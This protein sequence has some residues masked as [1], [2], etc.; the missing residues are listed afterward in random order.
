LDYLHALDVGQDTDFERL[1]GAFPGAE[2]NCILFPGWIESH[3]MDDVGRELLRLMELGKRF[4][5]FSFT[6]LEVDSRL[7]GDVLFEFHET[8]RRCAMG[9]AKQ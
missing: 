9:A 8:F 4:R 7:G 2:V 6:L 3:S 5:A 1:A